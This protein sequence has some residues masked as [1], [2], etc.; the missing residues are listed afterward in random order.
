MTC[1]HLLWSVLWLWTISV[2]NAYKYINMYFIKTKLSETHD[3]NYNKSWFSLFFQNRIEPNTRLK[4]HHLAYDLDSGAL[5]LQP[6][7]HQL[8]GGGRNHDGGRHSHFSGNKG[9]SHTSITSFRTKK[10]ESLRKEKRVM[11]RSNTQGQLWAGWECCTAA[12][13]SPE[14]HTTPLDWLASCREEQRRHSWAAERTI[15]TAG[16]SSVQLGLLGSYLLAQMSNPTDLEGAG[17]LRVLHLQVDGGA[18]EFGHG[19][20]LQQRRVEVEVS[21]HGI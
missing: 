18:D 14:E 3:I 9:R 7:R 5:I 11:L 13:M 8:R 2:I 21:R 19:C 12:E 1:G 6:L 15:L 20:T 16:S 4:W 10:D 17:G